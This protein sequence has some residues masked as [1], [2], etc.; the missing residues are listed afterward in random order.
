MNVAEKKINYLEHK[1]AKNNQSE[2]EK[3]NHKPKNDS[4]SRFWDNFKSS[5]I[6]IIGVPKKKQSKK[7]E[8]YLEKKN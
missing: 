8:I 3:R 1:E 5:N 7:S 2:Q 6:R 4:I